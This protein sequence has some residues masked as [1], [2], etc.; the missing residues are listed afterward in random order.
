[1]LALPY[2]HFR[3]GSN[4]LPRPTWHFFQKKSH[5]TRHY[6]KNTNLSNSFK[7]ITPTAVGPVGNQQSRKMAF[8]NSWTTINGDTS[9]LA[10]Y[11]ILQLSFSVHR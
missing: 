2:A 5:I 8:K 3:H 1:M 7:T 4:P 6:L 11:H 10:G 9:M